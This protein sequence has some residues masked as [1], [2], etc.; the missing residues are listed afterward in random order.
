MDDNN[1]NSRL[2]RDSQ[3]RIAALNSA[4]VRAGQDGGISND[5]IDVFGLAETYYGWLRGEVETEKPT[6]EKLKEQA[7]E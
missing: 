7:K 6:L 2:D 3:Y 4:V 5:P 1:H